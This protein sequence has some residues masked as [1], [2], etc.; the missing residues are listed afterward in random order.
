MGGSSSTSTG[1]ACPP[2]F[3]RSK[4]TRALKNSAEESS[5]SPARVTPLGMG[6][7]TYFLVVFRRTSSPNKKVAALST[8]WDLTPRQKDVLALVAEGF[9]NKTI[10]TRLTCTERTVEAH[11]T[12][13]FQKSGCDGRNLLLAAVARNWA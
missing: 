2:S 13:I 11:L 10:A 12:A 8:S 7:S 3:Q 1:T 6:K 9:S 5:S 4:R